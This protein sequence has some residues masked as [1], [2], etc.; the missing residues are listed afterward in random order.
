MF[1]IHS[2][3]ITLFWIGLVS[4]QVHV[5]FWGTGCRDMFLVPTPWQPANGWKYKPVLGGGESRKE[6]E[7]NGVGH[8]EDFPSLG[9]SGKTSQ[10]VLCSGVKTAPGQTHVVVM[11][12]YLER[13]NSVCRLQGMIKNVLEEERP[14]PVFNDYTSKRDDTNVKV[15]FFG[16]G[17]VLP[18]ERTSF[19]AQG[20]SSCLQSTWVLCLSLRR[21]PY[22]VLPSLGLTI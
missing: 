18:P 22:V 7:K 6:P 4:W 15:F 12:R 8:S 11:C 2:S 17:R 13:M 16:G 14:T 5:G 19:E 10:E 3:V 21:C 1:I 20:Q 9:V